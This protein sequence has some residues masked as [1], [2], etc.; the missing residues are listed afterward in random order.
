[1]RCAGTWNRSPTGSRRSTSWACRCSSP[2]PPS[3]WASPAAATADAPVRADRQGP[4]EARTMRRQSFIA[5]AVV[6]AVFVVGAVVAVDMRD[7]RTAA[8]AGGDRL[9]PALLRSDEHT[10]ELQ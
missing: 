5:L 3:A 1:M 9:F 2:S 8:I 7:E 4:G 10:S 6:T